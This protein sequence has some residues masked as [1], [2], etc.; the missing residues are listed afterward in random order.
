MFPSGLVVFQRQTFLNP[1]Q[2]QSCQCLL[3]ASLLEIFVRY[4]LVYGIQTV[5]VVVVVVVGL[6][7]WIYVLFAVVGVASNFVVA[8]LHVV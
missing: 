6:A 3:A 8:K 1:H 7:V 2:F 5:V 4:P